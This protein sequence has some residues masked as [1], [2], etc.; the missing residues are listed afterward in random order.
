MGSAADPS[1]AARGLIAAGRF[2][3]AY[4][5][6]TRKQ[7]AGPLDAEALDLLA[8]AAYAE[9]AYEEAISAFEAAHADH[10]AGG[11]HREAGEAAANVALH[12]MMDSGLMAPVRAWLARAGRLL[13]GQDESPPR[14]ILAVGH[15][16][17]RF[18]SGDLDMARR[19]AHQAVEVGRRQAV[20]PAV[21]M[22]TLVLGRLEIH[23]GRVDDGLALLDDV[24]LMCLSGELDGLTVGMAF[25]E[26]VCA[27]QGLGDHDRAEQ[28]TAAM[29]AFR[30]RGELVGSMR[31]RCRV[32]RA[33]LLRFRGEL[34]KAEEQARQACEE[35]RP[36]MRREFGW[37]LTELGTI[38]LCRG[39][40]DGAEEA[41]LSAYTSG[42]DPLPGLARLRLVQGDLAGASSMIEEALTH[43]R[44]IPW[45]E[46][47]PN[48]ALTRAPLLEAKVEIAVAAEDLEG[49]RAAADE[50]RAVAATF[51]S[52]SL[53]AMARLAEGRVA[54]AAGDPA[55]AAVASRDAVDGWCAMGAVHQAAIARQVLSGALHAGG[56][57]EAAA[58]EQQAADRAL[59]DGDRTAVRGEQGP[60]GAAQAAPDPAV[61]VFRC[62]GDT[63]K[64]VFNGTT[65]V[66]RD[67][68]GMRYLERL[69]AEPG[70]EFH[71]LDLVVD[72][73]GVPPAAAASVER[74]EVE[75]TG[76]DAGPILDDQA[77]AAYRRRLAEMDD[78]IAQAEAAGDIERIAMAKA[79]RDYL[80]TELSRAFGLRGR[81]RRASSDS[82]RARTSVTR[83]LRYTLDRIRQHHRALADHLE[84]AV[85]TGTYCSYAPDPRAPITWRT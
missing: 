80:V 32:H 53:A 1:T 3:E 23:A 10:L 74:G 17:E 39:D 68:K 75:V 62:D 56:R 29:E 58:L 18:L 30:D 4:E 36:W 47:P 8:R 21:A 73:H 41:F 61:A 84:Q 49:A 51:E 34:G 67:L 12:L 46:R 15:T 26:L 63:R 28:W 72:E 69:L 5:G 38:R 77:R 70:R 76:A 81:E 50:L 9:G 60:G 6:L 27:M 64:V 45:K 11:R 13:D 66:L 71:A 65:V 42:W 14:A 37:P 25:C 44:Q 59:A 78:D 22:G 16:Y 24:A 7:Q 35:L 19:W 83:S 57:I 48:M 54:L 82:E 33:E 2:A 55:L 52:R 20:R 40:L 43:P 79:D 31:G 85:S